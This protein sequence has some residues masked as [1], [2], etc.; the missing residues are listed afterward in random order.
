MPEKEQ[1]ETNGLILTRNRL[2][3]LVDGIFGFSMTLL[4]VNL[5]LPADLSHPS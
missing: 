4:V 3:A 2:E 5:S 1:S